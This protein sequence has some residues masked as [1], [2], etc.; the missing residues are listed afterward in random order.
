MQRDCAQCYARAKNG[1]A[2]TGD[3]SELLQK[4]PQVRVSLDITKVTN[5]EL[6]S[7]LQHQEG[8]HLKTCY[9]IKRITEDRS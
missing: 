7:L 3:F 5:T 9:Q 4:V 1:W 6:S 8:I 2:V